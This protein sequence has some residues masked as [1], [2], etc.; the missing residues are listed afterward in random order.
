MLGNGVITPGRAAQHD[1]A[2]ENLRAVLML[3]G[4][5]T[6]SI[7]SPDIVQVEDVIALGDSPHAHTKVDRDAGQCISGDDR[8]LAAASTGGRG[9]TELGGARWTAG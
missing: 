3:R 6:E 4:W 2:G 8:I 9:F 5:D 1:R 7:G